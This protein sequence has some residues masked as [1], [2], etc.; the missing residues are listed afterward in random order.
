MLESVRYRKH[1]ELVHSRLKWELE[2]QSYRKDPMLWV[3]K[4]LGENPM[5]IRW[6]TY[7]GYEGHRFDGSVD[8]LY[9]AWMDLTENHFVGLESATG[10]GKTYIGSRMIY[11]FLDCFVNSLVVI[12]GP[13]SAQLKA[14]MWSEI[15][16]AFPKFNKHRTEAALLTQE[17]RV[18]NVPDKQS[19]QAI[20]R[21]GS[22]GSESEEDQAKASLS[23]FHRKDMLFVF[24]EMQGISKDV[25]ETIE[26]TC[27]GEH[28][29]IVAFGNPDSQQDTLHKFCIRKDVKHY[30]V[31]GLDHPNVVLDKEIIAGAVTRK[32]IKRRKE[33][34]GED[35]PFFLSRVRGICPNHSMTDLFNLKMFDE[36]CENECEI[37]DSANA[38][39]IDPSNSEGGDETALAYGFR[40]QCM[41][42][43]SFNCPDCNLISDNLIKSDDQVLSEYGERFLYNLPKI[44]DFDVKP[45]NIGVDS[46]GVGIGTVNAF[47]NKHKTNV[48]SLNGAFKQD[49]DRV[50]KDEDKKPLYLFGNLRAQMIWQL[51]HD[52]NNQKISLVHVTNL[53]ALE[54][55]RNAM[56][57]T[58]LIV[59]NGKTYATPK[60]DIIRYVGNS[61]NE[62]DALIYWNWIRNNKNKQKTG[63]SMFSTERV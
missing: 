61:P 6:S 57:Y 53:E 18:I 20:M 13:T 1:L 25:L 59:T 7:E 50:P 52:V 10:T 62:F 40:N 54:S 29:L 56:R 17:L 31:S 14:N 11:W 4:R 5:S 38:I 48:V 44:N 16:T 35:S 9:N 32:S 15:R 34:Y 55:I 12:V 49:K 45:H 19:W 39:G 33:K 47:L 27:T 41:A 51:A 21:S 2:A 46:V 37:D 3:D 26:N 42:L 22:G 36:C 63:T 8:P 30:I 28:N 24:D 43:I 23:G 58:K 60:E